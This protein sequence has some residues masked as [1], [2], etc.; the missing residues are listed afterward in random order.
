MSSD[1]AIP[2]DSRKLASAL[3]RARAYL[4]ERQSPSGGFCFY[5]GYYAEEPNLSD[6]WHAIAVLIGLLGV[7]LPEK[8]SHASFVIGQP[9][10]PQPLLLYYRVRTLLALGADDPQ[11]A[12]VRSAVEALQ[13]HFPNIATQ[14]SL[15]A[16]LQR[17]RCTVWLKWHFGL[18]T[19]LD[20]LAMALLRGEHEGGG[21]GIPPNLLDTE[22]AI[23]VLMLCGHAP[24]P[25]TGDFVNRMAVAG[26]GF[27]LTAGSLSP[28]LETVCAGIRSCC[29]LGMPIPHARDAMAYVLS[30]QTG[31]GGFA[32]AAGALPDITLTHLALTTLAR[33]LAPLSM[34]DMIP[35]VC[36]A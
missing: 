23:A 28:N 2:V 19:A 24:L 10:A 27:R 25:R 17:I 14:A 29:R 30:C 36:D 11:S 6:T 35:A 3:N 7:D 4:L 18:P 26:F 1:F 5:R 15:S 13:A 34:K 12:E 31:N 9:I 32:R 20:D 22:A 21:Y 16:A 33:Q 8:N